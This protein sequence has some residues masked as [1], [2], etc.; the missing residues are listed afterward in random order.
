LD[1]QSLAT[2]GGRHQSMVHSGRRLSH[3]IDPRTG[4]PA[5]GVYSVTVVTGD[6]A[7]ADALATAMFVLGADASLAFCK[8]H[9]EVSVLLLLPS[10]T[11]SRELDVVYAG[12]AGGSLHVL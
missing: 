1:D 6:A 4:R 2:S 10:T 3:V 9:P 7:Q 11:R 12:F 5:E 8:R